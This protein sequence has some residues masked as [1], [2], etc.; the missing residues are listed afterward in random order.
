MV[1]NFSDRP[2]P[3]GSV[4]RLLDAALRAPSAG[5]T[6]GREFVVLEG[7]AETARY[8]EA[9]TDEAWRT[10]SRRFEGLRRAPVVVLPFADPDAYDARYGE[11][12]KAGTDLLGGT[13]GAGTDRLGR[14][15][16]AGTDRLGGTDGAGTDRRP[17]ADDVPSVAW[18]VP[19][20]FVDTGYA[21]MSMLL[22]A[23]D[24]G[25]G[26]AFLGNFRGE[27]P[28]RV[29]LGVPDCL[30]WF[31]AVLFGEPAEPDPASSSLG[32]P[33][34]TRTDSVHRGAWSLPRT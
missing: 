32:R 33:K 20:W 4:D 22:V 12:D 14:T 2:L 19:Y 26:A 28:L 34:R 31:G 16:W 29:A 17:G 11:P 23:T 7:P 6:Q 18:P 30:R 21:V 27:E 25:I 13:D 15:D 9:T 1:R 10:R 8:W 5:N 24:L 3:E